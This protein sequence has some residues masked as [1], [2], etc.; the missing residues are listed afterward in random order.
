MHVDIRW[1]GLPKSDALTEHVQN[2]LRFALHGFQER[3]R[4][5]TIRFEDVN[6]P[7]GG[8]DKRCS[9]ELTG[10]FGIAVAEARDGDFYRAADL[11][12]ARA[13]RAVA[14]SKRDRPSRERIAK[15]APAFRD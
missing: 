4:T 7:R 11:A 1:K 8:I 15:S 5:V 14:K 9:I 3:I 2:R 10:A 6:G 12:L 13:E